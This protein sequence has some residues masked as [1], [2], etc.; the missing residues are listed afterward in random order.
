LG[1]DLLVVYRKVDE[2]LVIDKCFYY[3]IMIKNLILF[4]LRGRVKFPTGGI[5][6]NSFL[7]PRAV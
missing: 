2:H 3:A 4:I 7:S 6:T 1:I 5:E